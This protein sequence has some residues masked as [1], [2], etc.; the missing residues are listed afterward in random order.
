MSTKG[1]IC[2]VLKCRVHYYCDPCYQESEK[3]RDCSICT[4]RASPGVIVFMDNSNIWIEAKKTAGL[5]SFGS[6]KIEDPR[7]RL[8]IGNLMD[9]LILNSNI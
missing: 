4:S 5:K 7:L 3:N 9:L 1:C 6:Q 2:I 8:D